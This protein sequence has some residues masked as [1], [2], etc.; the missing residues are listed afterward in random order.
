VE[1]RRQT[2]TEKAIRRHREKALDELHRIM[3]GRDERDSRHPMTESE[4]R[5]RW[6]VRRHNRK[7]YGAMK[8]R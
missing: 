7:L 5:A 8:L 2:V 4:S 1:L 6:E 3:G